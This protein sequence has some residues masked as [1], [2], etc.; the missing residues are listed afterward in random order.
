M[1]EVPQD[2]RPQEGRQTE[3]LSSPADI[4]IY[5]GAAGGGKTWGLLLE[6]L[7]H[8]GND[9]F[10]AV[11]FRRTYKEISEEG[12]MWDESYELYPHL[13][14]E[15]K[16]GSYRWTFPSG[17]KISFRHMQ[18][19]KDH[20]GY[21]GAQIA[22]LA[23]DQLEE[24]E[25][26]QFFY[27][28]SRNRS[29]SGVK[30][31]VRAT[32][33]PQPGWL[34]DFLAWWIDQDT[35]LPIP[36]R[37]GKVR[38]M[39]RIGEDLVWSSHRR[40]LAAQGVIPKSVAFVPS[41]VYDNKLLLAKDPAYLANLQALPYVERER[42]LGGNWKVKEEAGKLYNRDWFEIIAEAPTGGVECG[43]WDFAATKKTFAKDDPDH[44]ARVRVRKVGDYY[45]VTDCYAAQI[46]P[47]QVDHEFKDQN[48]SDAE[49]LRRK[50]RFM[51]RWE[52]EPGSAGI[53]EARR[54]TNQLKGIDAR[55]R[56]PDGDKIAR[57]KPWA[58]QAEQGF[59]KLVRGT[60]NERFLTH[61]HHQPFP[62]WPHD[63]IAD[64]FAGAMRGVTS[65]RVMQSATID[66]YAQAKA[67]KAKLQGVMVGGELVM[68]EEAGMSPADAEKALEEFENE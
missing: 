5:G 23:F 67:D 22:F 43:F 12:G 51:V 55:G 13:G 19:S 36:E 46:G 59:V 64:G 27:M 25:E 62:D 37:A 9:K 21:K 40:E 15:A 58:A 26:E 42:L 47:A 34:A 30:P 63:D 28:L 8:I 48:K 68:T 3:F 45:Y 31:Y 33:N 50:T 29:T 44:T 10:G 39:A 17:A 24:F 41:T 16:Q 1:I 32:C 20:L 35:G 38:W 2:I 60:W 18:H 53:R 66:F 11:I 14:A 7:R 52:I 56:R 65:D 49:D 57:Q 61:M 54:L 4:V 6:A